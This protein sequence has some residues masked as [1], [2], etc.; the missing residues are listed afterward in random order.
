MNELEQREIISD[1]VKNLE[2]FKQNIID[3]EE[4]VDLAFTKID[5]LEDVLSNIGDVEWSSKKLK[6]EI[7]LALIRN[8]NF[9]R[10][11][12][13]LNDF[14][15]QEFDEW[16]GIIDNTLSYLSEIEY[17]TIIK[18]VL[19]YTDHVLQDLKEMV[20]SKKYH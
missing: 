16:Y 17:F 8:T 11:K 18:D 12:E 20:Q 2:T 10:V 3:K 9:R 1:I 15:K 7:V 6:E 13:K 19:N 4:S 5:D 14:R